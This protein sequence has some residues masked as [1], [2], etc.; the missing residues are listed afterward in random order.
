L[1]QLL[2]NKCVALTKALRETNAETRCQH[3]SFI[4]HKNKLITIG[5]NSKK[6]NPT[7]IKNPKINQEGKRIKNKYTCSE[8]HA[9]IKFKNMTNI[10]FG[11][12]NLVVTRID[13]NGRIRGS[14]P[15]TSCQNLLNFLNLKE[16]YYT[17]DSDKDSQFEKF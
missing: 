16:I 15:C 11:K 10:P 2:L 4:F 9:F 8:L 1:N 3:F 6:S 12:V 14:K 13:R 17:V 7:N 5:K